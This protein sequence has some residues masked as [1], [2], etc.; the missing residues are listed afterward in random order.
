M[1]KEFSL[2]GYSDLLETAIGNKYEFLFFDEACQAK[3]EKFC[4]LR[5]DIDADLEAAKSISS[6]EKEQSVKAT[7]FVML[8]SPVYNLFG[9]H[10][11]RCVE[12][13]LKNGHQLALHYDEGFYPGNGRELQELVEIEADT[14]FKIFG[15]KITTVSF[16]QPGPKVLSN[17]I[18]LR[19]FINT[20]DKSDMAGVFYIS[21]SNMIW[22]NMSAWDLFESNTEPKI[23]LLTHPMWWVGN[24]GENTEVLWDRA[25]HH[26]IS[27]TLDQIVETER[28]FGSRR[29]I[30]I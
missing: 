15:Q 11:H 4:L 5:H 13:I 14:L 26:N 8:R 25:I 22:K 1:Q 29:H 7:Y 9:R 28:A 17:E 27:R 24:G 16:H 21:D 18:K 3:K 10:N 6:I 30:H 19:H 20:Y 2:K 12:Q 23:Q